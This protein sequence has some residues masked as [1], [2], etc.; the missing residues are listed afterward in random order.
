MIPYAVIADCIKDRTVVPVLGAAA[1]FNSQ[2]QAN[3]LYDGKGFGT[4]LAQKA[5]YPGNASDPLTKIAQYVD[6]VASDRDY[7]L[8][9]IKE[10]FLDDLGPDYRSYFSVL[11]A[12]LDKTKFPKLI[13]TTN[14]DVSVE[15]AFE[16]ATMPYIC[17]SHIMRPSRYTGRYLCYRALNSPLDASSILTKG[18]I[19]E[20]LDE[21]LRNT[22]YTTLIYKM[23]GTSKVE[24]GAELINSVVL[25]ENDYI[26]FLDHNMIGKIPTQIQNFLRDARLLFLGYSLQDWNFRVLLHR[27]RE[28]QKVRQTERKHWA[29]LL[30]ADQVERQ[31]WEKR[32]VN[33]YTLKLDEFI[34]QLTEALRHLNIYVG[35]ATQVINAGR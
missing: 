22:P 4:F 1:S 25:T 27:I 10:R 3:S 9:R 32:G 26:D 24:L 21:I 33:L 23:H 35:S 34:G 16:R 18:Q 13:I 17:I 15:T 2:P 19:E 30:D 7:I 20:E 29:C 14:Y 11:L 31:F 6:E 5:S 8:Q 28:S 12:N